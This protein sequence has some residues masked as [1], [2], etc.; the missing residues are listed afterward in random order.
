MNKNFPALLNIFFLLLFFPQFSTAQHYKANVVSYSPSGSIV[1]PAVEQLP[2]SY[3]SIG[4]SNIT[5]WM[6]QVA[7]FGI[8]HDVPDPEKLA[9]IKQALNAI[10]VSTVVPQLYLKTTSNTVSTPLVKA[11]YTANY[12]YQGTPPDNSLAVSEDGFVVSAINSNIIYFSAA[13]VKVFEKTFSDFFNDSTLSSSLYDP[14]LLYDSRSNHFIFILLNGT[15]SSTS[16]LVVSF[17]KTS[18]PQDGW[19]TYKFKMSKFYTKRWLDYPKAGIS[20]NDLFITGNVFSDAGSF[21][22]SMMLQINKD[23]GYYGKTLNYRMWKTIKDADNNNAFSMVPVSYGQKGS[24]GP[25]IYL[26]SSTNTGASRCY[27]YNVSDDLG[28]TP[29]MT[30]FAFT[31]PAYSIGGDAIQNA[32]SDLLD[33]GDCRIK[34]AFYLDG[35]IHFV[36]HT[37]IDSIGYNGINYNRLNVKDLVDE[38]ALLGT[39]GYDMAYPAVAS[40]GKDSSRKNV[41]IAFLMSGSDMY[42]QFNAVYCDDDMAFSDYILLKKG[43]T[44]VDFLTGTERWG[45]YTGICRKENSGEPSVWASGCYGASI[46]TM[47]NTYRTW[48]SEIVPGVNTSVQDQDLNGNGD[49]ISVFPNPTADIIHVDLNLAKRKLVEISLYNINGTLVRLL[50]KDYTEEGK[51]MLSFNRNALTA[52]TYFLTVRENGK[53]VKTQKIVVE[54]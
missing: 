37:I 45:D 49:E 19:N 17:S 28:G 41:I 26:I 11:K 22:E 7:T 48:I 6:T 1:A 14:F 47:N 29:I 16:T 39:S 42:P 44:Y 51:L 35:T 38:Q 15:S 32:N 33:V 18:N 46:S 50:Y 24:Y 52:G 23:S 40:S 30:K 5:N 12:T 34:S 3:E 4:H 31:L 9:S 13:G 54:N 53:A 20:N 8:E 21:R 2:M 36:F 27:L 43:V 10:K 25:G